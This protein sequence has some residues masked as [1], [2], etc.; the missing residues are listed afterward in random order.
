MYVYHKAAFKFEES[1]ATH[2]DEC[3][4]LYKQLDELS[5]KH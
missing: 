5:W 3:I 2:T 4:Q 1:L